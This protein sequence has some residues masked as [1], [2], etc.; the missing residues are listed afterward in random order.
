MVSFGRLRMG[1]GS[2]GQ[3][4]PQTGWLIGNDAVDASMQCGFEVGRFIYRIYPQFQP[5]GLNL[6]GALGMEMTVVP[7]EDGGAG[8][9]G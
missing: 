2:Q 6:C 7:N 8:F 3:V 9:L 4:T 1:I 5:S